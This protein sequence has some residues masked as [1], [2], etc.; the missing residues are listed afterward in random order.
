MKRQQLGEPLAT[1]P[2]EVA[3]AET[4][5]T[6]A[7]DTAPLVHEGARREREREIHQE[8]SRG[9][10]ELSS[11]SSD[12][13]RMRTACLCVSSVN[14][15]QKPSTR[16]EESIVERREVHIKHLLDTGTVQDW[17][18]SDVDNTS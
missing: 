15:L 12:P 8:T 2:E 3:G 4:S 14:A 9:S 7:D 16:S 1:I 11:G 17:I 6:M 5:D 13:K 10:E 18:A